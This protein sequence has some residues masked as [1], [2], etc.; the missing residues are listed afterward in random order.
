MRRSSPSAWRNDGV[1]IIM[2][3]VDVQGHIWG[4]TRLNAHGQHATD[5]TGRCRRGRTNCR[6]RWMQPA[7]VA[8]RSCR[9]PG[10]GTGT[11]APWRPRPRGAGGRSKRTWTRRIHSACS[12]RYATGRWTSMTRFSRPQPPEGTAPPGARRRCWS[13]PRRSCARPAAPPARWGGGAD[14]CTPFA[15]AMGR[16]LGRARGGRRG[17]RTPTSA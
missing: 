5:R 13:P 7:Y 8:P 2:L 14:P 15:K 10:R 3:I 16:T 12:G 17:P 9:P 11:I 6:A 1:R 4:R